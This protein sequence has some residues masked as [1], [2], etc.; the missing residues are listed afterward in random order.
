M[1][2]TYALYNVI[3]SMSSGQK[4]GI[5]CGFVVRQSKGDGSLLF[6]KF[7]GVIAKTEKIFELYVWLWQG[8]ISVLQSN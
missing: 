7:V 4:C 6:H 3:W 1:N 5:L 8:F 2:E